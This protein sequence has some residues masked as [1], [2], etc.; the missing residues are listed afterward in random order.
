MAVIDDRFFCSKRCQETE[1]NRSV[2]RC[3][4]CG[5]TWNS[6]GGAASRNYCNTAWIVCEDCSASQKICVVCGERV[7][8]GVVGA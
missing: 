3:A 1:L 4:R 2:H 6:Q 7:P 5:E 8:D